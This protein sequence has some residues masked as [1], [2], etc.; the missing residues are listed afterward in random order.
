MSA[1]GSDTRPIRITRKPVDYRNSGEGGQAEGQT[2]QTQGVVKRELLRQG[3]TRNLRET[4]TE[5]VWG[6]SHTQSWSPQT[7]RQ[8]TSTICEGVQELTEQLEMAKK[9]E[10]SVTDLMALMLEMAKNDKADARRREEEREERAIEREEKRLREQVDREDERRRQEEEKEEERRREQ[11]EREDAQARREEARERETREMIRALRE[12]QA[13]VPQTVHIK[14]TRLPKMVQGE[15]VEVFMELFEAALT[16]NGIPDNKWKGKLHASLDTNTKLKVRDHIKDPAT[17]YQ[18]IKDAL[19]GCGALTFS[20]ASETLLTADRGK[21]LNLPFRQ[22]VHKLHRLVEKISSEATTVSE[23]CMCTAVAIARYHMDP[24]LKRYVD[25]KGEFSKDKICQTAE[26][27][28]ATQPPG[29]R[30]A[31][32]KHLE[33]KTAHKLPLTKKG[34]ACFHCGK[35][36]HYSKECR[37]RLAGEIPTKSPPIP[38]TPTIKQEQPNPSQ[39][40]PYKREITCFSCRQ[41]GHKSPQCPL[42]IKQVKKIKI[43]AEKVVPLARNEVFGSMGKYRLPITCDTGAQVTLVPEECVEPSQFTGETS[44]LATANDTKFEGKRCEIDVTIDGK[45]FHRNAVTQPG[46]L[47]CWT[48]CLSIDG[49]LTRGTLHPGSDGEEGPTQRG[50]YLILTS[51]DQGRSSIV[52]SNGERGKSGA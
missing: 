21:L 1:E 3:E 2:H 45:V 41:V 24:D 30:W 51:R 44:V 16:D 29:A 31:K 46:K 9:E 19:I 23:S 10:I 37:S 32:I 49:R 5:S 4:S 50:R 36:G 17:T 25:V 43:P 34:S 47:L 13:P 26:E 38:I 11:Q 33:E 22:A 18:D 15:D 28:Q 42:R 14:N 52:W 35:M 6:G 40:S 48:V 27:W 39:P 8:R 12:A 20:N 7:I